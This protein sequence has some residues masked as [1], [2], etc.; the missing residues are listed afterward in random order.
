MSS[1]PGQFQPGNQ[2]S[3]LGGEAT[4]RSPKRHRFARGNAQ[5]A[6]GGRAR[7]E[8]L[9]PERRAEIAS[10]GGKAGWAVLVER[11][12]AGDEDAAKEFIGRRG[13]YWAERLAYGDDPLIGKPGVWLPPIAPWEL[14]ARIAPQCVATEDQ[15]EAAAAGL[16]PCPF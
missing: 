12:F 4:A 5:A 13:A 2:I 3:R 1:R 6:A 11:W 10:A 7:A 14:A 15:I 8:K 9:Q 16:I